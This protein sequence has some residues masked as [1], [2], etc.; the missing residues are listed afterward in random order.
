MRELKEIWRQGRT[1]G[2][3]NIRLACS[4]VSSSV[5]KIL[6]PSMGYRLK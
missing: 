5:E 1:G 6:G 4:Q 2:E 3:S